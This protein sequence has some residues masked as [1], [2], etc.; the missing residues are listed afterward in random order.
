VLFGGLADDPRDGDPLVRRLVW[1]RAGDLERL[2]L[3]VRLKP[4]L[5]PSLMTTDVALE[6]RV[7]SAILKEAGT[8]NLPHRELTRP[9]LTDV[10]TEFGLEGFRDG[11]PGVRIEWDQLPPERLGSIAAWAGRVRESLR[12]V[13]P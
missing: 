10:P 6:A 2:Q 5:D 1:D 4:N 3:G 9:Y 11:R 7:F 12:R 8:L 13:L